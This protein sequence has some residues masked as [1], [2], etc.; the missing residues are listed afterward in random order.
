[1]TCLPRPVT[2]MNCSIPAS[3]ASSTAYWTTGLSITGSISLGTA[4]VAGRKRV[5]MP[6]TGRTALRTGLGLVIAGRDALE[7]AQSWHKD[8]HIVH[9]ARGTG[10]A[11]AKY[12]NLADRRGRLHRKPRGGR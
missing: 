12:A 8:A 7:S 1:M 2:K 5:P 3:I 11:G 9:F 10:Y 6:A 4:L